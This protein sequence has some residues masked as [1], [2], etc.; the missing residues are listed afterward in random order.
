MSL[1]ASP[2]V[3]SATL[4][5]KWAR[6][7]ALRQALALQCLG[8]HSM[9][10][11]HANP[12]CVAPAL[13]PAVPSSAARLRGRVISPSWSLLCP[14]Q[15]DSGPGGADL[16]SVMGVPQGPLASSLLLPPA[17]GCVL[18]GGSCM[19]PVPCFGAFPALLPS[20]SAALLPVTFGTE[21]RGVRVDSN[22]VCSE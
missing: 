15:L 18:G 3:I 13:R 10:M 21:G 19:G 20:R 5:L 11:M 9:C 17:R 1:L 12:P 2:W 6:T 4:G 14:E 8:V 7:A 16:W 22:R